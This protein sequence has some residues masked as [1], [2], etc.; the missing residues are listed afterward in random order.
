MFG[1]RDTAIASFKGSRNRERSRQWPNPTADL[2]F[3]SQRSWD[4]VRLTV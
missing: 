3:R 2:L 4:C 1:R